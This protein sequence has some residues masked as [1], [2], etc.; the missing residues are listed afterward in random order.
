MSLKKYHKPEIESLKG[1]A[2]ILI[3]LYNADLYFGGVRL[4]QG[5]FLG[6]DILFLISGYLMT[7]TALRETTYNNHFSIKIFLKKRISR[8]IPLLLV[9]ILTSLPFAWFILLPID[10]L[11][12]AKSI[13]STLSFNSNYF[14]YYSGNFFAGDSLI[15]KPFVHTWSLSVL[16]QFYLLFSIVLLI[17]IKHFRKQFLV[18]LIAIL[19]LSLLLAQ[20]TSK[21]N[22]ELN[23]YV[24]QTRIWEFLSGSIIGYFVTKQKK[25]APQIL[26]LLAITA[27]FSLVFYSTLFFKDTAPHPSFYTLVPILGILLVIWFSNTKNLISK[28]L[29]SKLFVGIGLISFSLYLWHYPVFAFYKIYID[30]PIFMNSWVFNR[31]LIFL[32]IVSLSLLSYFLIEKKIKEN[33]IKFSRILLIIFFKLIIILIISINIISTAGYENRVPESVK[34]KLSYIDYFTKEYRDC[35]VKFDINKNKF[36]KIGNFNKNVFLIGDSRAAF[37]IENL[38]KKLINNKYNLNIYTGS[39]LDF[40]TNLQKKDLEF[41]KIRNEELLKSKNSIIIINGVYNNKDNDFKFMSQYKSFLSFFDLLEKNNN[42]IIFLQPIPIIMNPY[43]YSGGNMK[44][45]NLI[46]NK[47]ISEYKITKDEYYKT[48]VDYSKFQKLITENSKNVIFLKTEDIFC[49][50]EFCYS[51]KDGFFLLQ[52]KLHQSALSADLINNLIIKQIKKIK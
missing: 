27:G 15:K 3:I 35:F 18:I 2:V 46:K 32:T 11:H 4:F 17:V 6:I 28:L 47:K 34:N 30:G 31:V 37:L 9:I 50:I 14:F 21:D 23:F 38:K 10:F 49:D 52:D 1:I 19:I 36:C 13:I 29:S 51:I 42:K 41:N 16:I 24:L 20:F 33:K 22:P 40:R 25:S 8:I 48:L 26:N 44:L 43:K 45:V 12:F 39:K 7:L 5:G